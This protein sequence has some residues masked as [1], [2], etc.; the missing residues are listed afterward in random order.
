[1]NRNEKN[2]YRKVVGERLDAANALILAEYRGLTVEEVT[3]LR[4]ALKKHNASF[5]VCKNRLVKKAI[6]G[7][8]GQYKDLLGKFKGPLGV[9]YSQG[10]SAQVTKT[11]LEF[12]KDHPNFKITAGFIDSASMSPSDLKVISDLPSKEVL[13]AQIVGSIVAPHRGLLGVLN[14]V[15]RQLVQVLNAIKEKKQ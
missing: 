5:Q 10:D 15:S 14:G 1:M 12:E 6:E 2:E 7:E 4:V 3:A 11:A 13:L 8:V 9:I